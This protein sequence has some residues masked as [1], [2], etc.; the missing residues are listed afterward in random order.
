MRLARYGDALEA[1]RYHTTTP[2]PNSLFLQKVGLCR[3]A[4]AIKLLCSIQDLP[5][6]TRKHASGWILI[7]QLL[8]CISLMPEVLV[9]MLQIRL[10][11]QYLKTDVFSPSQKGGGSGARHCWCCFDQSCIH[12]SS[13][14]FSPVVCHYHIDL[15]VTDSSFQDLLDMLGLTRRRDLSTYLPT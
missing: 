7:P 5:A 1:Y 2:N 14:I 13:C 4:S 8:P 3:A 6:N 11:H 10:F 12:R 15:L 9:L